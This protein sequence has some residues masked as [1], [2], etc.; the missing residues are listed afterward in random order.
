[1]MRSVLRVTMLTGVA[2]MAAGAQ[3]ALSAPLTRASQ[4]DTWGESAAIFADG[5]AR[6]RIVESIQ[7][8]YGARVVRVT[9][10]TIAG[11]RVFELR[12]LSNQRVW[13][14]SVDAESGREVAET[15]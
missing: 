11:R 13:M 5:D 8:K 12:L 9:E 14:V 15:E 6:D 2:L 7:R 1:M 3:R 10:V 4:P